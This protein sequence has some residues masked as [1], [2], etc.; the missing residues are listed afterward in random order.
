[1]SHVVVYSESLTEKAW[2]ATPF[3]DCTFRLP[4][5]VWKSLLKH[6]MALLCLSVCS[7]T[8]VSTALAAQRSQWLT[9][10]FATPAHLKRS[11]ILELNLWAFLFFIFCTHLTLRFFW[12]SKQ[13]T[14]LII[15]WQTSQLISSGYSLW[16]FYFVLFVSALVFD[17]LYSKS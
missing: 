3:C 9:I 13:V 17:Q 8:I 2:G 7:F 15:Y 1:M 4:A 16:V 14:Y 6:L 11:W 12:L 10:S 5:Y